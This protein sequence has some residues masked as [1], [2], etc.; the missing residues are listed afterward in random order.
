MVKELVPI[1][2]SCAVWGP[3]FKQRST[4]FNCDNQGL[5]AAINKG[6]SKDTMVMHFLKCLWFF[7]AAFD[8]HITPTH[9][10]GKINNTADM[11]SRNQAAKFL[12]A[13]P[14]MLTIPTPF[15]PS[16]LHLVSPQ[17]LDWTS[18]K[19]HRLF[20]KT[21]LHVQQYLETPKTI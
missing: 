1:I 17:M 2:I 18:P 13:H 20:R 16:F 4:E 19:F 5:A 3:L 15:P 21:Y 7:T 8:I 11:L 10:T 9:I 14:H 12:K 6:L